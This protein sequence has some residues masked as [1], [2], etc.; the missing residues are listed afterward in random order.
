MIKRYSVLE[1][2]EEDMKILGS[3]PSVDL[4]QITKVCTQL[5][6]WVINRVTIIIIAELLASLR[7]SISKGKCYFGVSCG[8]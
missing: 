3:R 6:S 4:D 7:L 1:R 2:P 8:G 5:L